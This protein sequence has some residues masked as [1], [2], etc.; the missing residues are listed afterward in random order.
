MDYRATSPTIQERDSLK[1]QGRRWPRGPTW[2][3]GISAGN[4]K[5]ETRRPTKENKLVEFN[6]SRLIIR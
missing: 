5:V 3:L 1:I 6:L 2:R 4:A